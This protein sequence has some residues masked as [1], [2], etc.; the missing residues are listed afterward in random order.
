MKKSIYVLL[1]F[2]I[3]Q[4]AFSQEA[5]KEPVFKIKG[6]SHPESVVWDDKNQVIYV[7]NI[8]DK[9]AGDGFISKLSSEGKVLDLKWITG[10]ND[11]KGLLVQNDKLYVTDNTALV[12]IDLSEAKIIKRTAVEGADFLNDI[13]ADEEGNLWI[14]D[15][16][17]SS[18]YLKAPNEGIT[19]WLSSPDLE[20]PNG[21]LTAGNTI[22][23]A[24][25]G[26][27]E[28][29]NILEVDRS[30][31][32]IKKISKKGIG[33][34]DGLQKIDD[35][36]FYLSDWATG[37]IHKINKNGAQVE[38]LTSAK[39]A[40]DILFLEDR[41]ILILPMNHQNEVWWYSLD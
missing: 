18:I 1:I 7:S 39:S 20:Q 21:L 33:N 28:P 3:T 24:A 27:E 12:E 34:L 4:Q 25:W 38:I 15:T 41:N 10:L 6:F 8:G 11:P 23:V 29:G 30:S 9:V 32:T 16:G 14:S 26:K 40:G 13:T 5:G 35:E 19:C 2:C 36:S 22:L 31:K 37:K 17:N